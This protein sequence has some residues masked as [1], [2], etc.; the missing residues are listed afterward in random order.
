[1]TNCDNNRDAHVLMTAQDT[2]NA[3]PAWHTIGIITRAYP[4]VSFPKKQKLPMTEASRHCA[5]TR[6]F[7]ERRNIDQKSRRK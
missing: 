6:E 3:V 4:A 7:Y 2:E 5:A 1:M